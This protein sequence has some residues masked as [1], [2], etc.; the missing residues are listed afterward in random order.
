MWPP[1]RTVGD[2]TPARGQARQVRGPQG[3]RAPQRKP[4]LRPAIKR[5]RGGRWLITEGGDHA[6]GDVASSA[7]RFCK[8]VRGTRNASAVHH[9]CVPLIPR[10]W[11]LTAQ[12]TSALQ[13]LGYVGALRDVHRQN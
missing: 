3:C 6:D 9:R 11:S 7:L 8:M 1:C 12:E 5:T 4:E 2:S 10:A 13:V